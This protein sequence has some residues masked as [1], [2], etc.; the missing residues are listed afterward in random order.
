M[1]KNGIP[2]MR[3]SATVQ[4]FILNYLLFISGL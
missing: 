4:Y 2:L 1:I 3:V